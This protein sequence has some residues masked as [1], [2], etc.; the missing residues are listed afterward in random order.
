MKVICQCCGKEFEKSNSQ[1]KQSPNHFCSCSCSAKVNNKKFQKRISSTKEK[2]CLQCNKLTK[3]SKYCSFEC[4][5]IH[6]R[7]EKEKIIESNGFSY[8]STN[9]TIRN[10]LKKKNGNCCMLCGMNAENWNGKELVLIVDHIDGKSTNN[11]MNNLRIIC[12]NCDSQ[13]D[14]YKAKNKGNSSRSYY[15]VQKT[16]RGGEARTHIFNTN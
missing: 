4:V 11:D 16:N 8:K 10:F 13:L 5:T 9:K 1:I 2:K 14:T 3:N 7:S 6:R 15:I 12:P